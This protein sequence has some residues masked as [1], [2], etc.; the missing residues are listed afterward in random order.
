M[1]RR[2]AITGLGVVSPF[3]VGMSSLWDGLCSGVSAVARITRFDPSA[4]ECRLAGEIKDFS[5]KDHVPK[6]YRKAVKVMSRDI[7]LAVAAAKCAVEDAGLVTR[8]SLGEEGQGA[9]SYPAGRVGCHIGAGLVAAEIDELTSALVTATEPGGEAGKFSYTRWGETG[10]NNLQPLWMLKYLPNMLACHVT[11]IHGA[12]GPSNTITCAEASGLLSVGESCRVIERDA[13]DMCFSGSAESKVN[14]MGLVRMLLA[15]RLGSTGDAASGPGAC[16]P[17]DPASV[18]VAGEAGGIV[19]LE[20]LDTAKARGATIMAEVIG[21]GA[22][23]SGWPPYTPAQ[24]REGVRAR[25]DRGLTFAIQRAISDAGITPEDIDAVVPQGSGSRL[26]DEGEAG[27]LRLIFGQRLASIPLVLLCPAIGNS[28]AGTG[29]VMVAVAAQ[30]LAKQQLPA[31]LQGGNPDTGL[32]AGP[33]PGGPTTLRHILV[34]G[35]STG[36]QNAAL[37]LRAPQ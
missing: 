9:T 37:V 28:F 16:M 22:A 21:F 24:A 5:A 6:H 19:A 2:I 32:L 31:R 13:A 8:A 27:T 1:H 3:G 20:A 7:E 15:G 18:G 14:P 23:H 17:F 29:G 30:A 26:E 33:S 25:Q 34:C 36:G 35:S 12:E 4:F 10:L 11:I